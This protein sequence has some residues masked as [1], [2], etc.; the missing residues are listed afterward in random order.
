MT[1]SVLLANVFG[2]VLRQCF[3][4]HDFAQGYLHRALCK[5][6][7]KV[8][9]TWANFYHYF[10]DGMQDLC[11]QPQPKYFRSS[12]TPVVIHFY[13]NLKGDSFCSLCL[14]VH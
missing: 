11:F 6:L 8:K 3:N 13:F 14:L 9:L 7:L 4:G 12:P 2:L 10:H 1:E 5:K